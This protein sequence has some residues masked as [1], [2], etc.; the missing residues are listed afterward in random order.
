[1]AKFKIFTSARVAECL[2]YAFARGL[3]EGTKLKYKVVPGPRKT[4]FVTVSTGDEK[5]GLGVR[6]LFSNNN[7][8]VREQGAR[9]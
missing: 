7:I 2:L 6:D 8:G 9:R 3:P 5:I 1:M 4:S